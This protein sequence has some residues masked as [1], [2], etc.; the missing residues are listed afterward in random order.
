MVIELESQWQILVDACNIT[1]VQPEVR[2]M[3]KTVT[4]LPCSFFVE[5]LTNLHGVENYAVTASKSLQ[6]TNANIHHAT[7]G[8]HPAVD[9]LFVSWKG[10]LSP[11]C[12]SM[13]QAH[14]SKLLMKSFKSNEAKD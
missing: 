9:A 3:K 8:R 14:S 6:Q 11:C 7:K 4:C 10:H 2:P 12:F 1:L 13:R 5:S